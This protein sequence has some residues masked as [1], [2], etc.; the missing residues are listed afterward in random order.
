[1]KSRS[2]FKLTRLYLTYH[3]NKIA[4]IVLGLVLLIWIVVLML[5]TGF[6]LEM[7]KYSLEPKQF[8]SFFLEQSIFFLQLID[9]V[10]I[11]FLI[12]TEISS[13]SLFDPMLVPNVSRVKI[14]FS[15]LLANFIIFF[16]ILA[17][18]ILSL[19]LVAVIVFPKY[20]SSMTRF[21]LLLYLC[22]PFLELL[23]IGELISLILNSYFIP[24][25][26]YII[27]I[28]STIL[29]RNDHYSKVLSI[30]I[31]QIII[32]SNQV[33]F[34]GDI[35]IFLGIAALLILCIALLFQKKDINC[36]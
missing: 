30:F 14:I 13:F 15:K 8:H 23:L 21:M 32:Q 28:L 33:V 20:C 19:E 5:N 2:I 26:I 12:G 4:L 27:H 1:M 7:E 35:G 18:Q 31:P 34:I 36:G 25:L 16:L 24:I 11:A 22:F 10:V 6:P 17:F 9:G 3:L 29:M